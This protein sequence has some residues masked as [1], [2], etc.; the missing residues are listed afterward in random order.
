M[1][2]FDPPPK[3]KRWTGSRALV[4]VEPGVCPVCGTE[5]VTERLHEPALIRHGGYGATRRTER[6][7]CPHKHPDGTLCGWVLLREVTEE[8]PA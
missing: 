2:L 7:Y 1:S 4:P 8:R 6:A 3:K 5:L